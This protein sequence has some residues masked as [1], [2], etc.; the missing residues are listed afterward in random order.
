MLF[1]NLLLEKAICQL[2]T[3]LTNYL[4]YKCP[5]YGNVDEA[6]KLVSE[7]SMIWIGLTQ[8]IKISNN[9]HCFSLPWI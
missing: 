2:N 9:N 3:L 7:K 5:S 4:D 8:G 6:W 1:L